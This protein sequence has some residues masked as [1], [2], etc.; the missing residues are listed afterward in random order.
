MGFSKHEPSADSIILNMMWL[1][2]LCKT[3]WKMRNTGIDCT[4]QF[5]LCQFS[6]LNKE[7]MNAVL[8]GGHGVARLCICK[9][10]LLF[11]PPPFTGPLANFTPAAFD[12]QPEASVHLHAGWAPGPD[13]GPKAGQLRVPSPF[14]GCGAARPA[15]T[16][17]C[18]SSNS[19]CGPGARGFPAEKKKNIKQTMS[20]VLSLSRTEL[21]YLLPRRIVYCLYPTTF[22]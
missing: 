20:C 18:P 10:C 8:R 15:R 1:R 19:V 5:Q 21:D 17:S 9:D 6:T 13:L 4:M 22:C 3:T 2:M 11:L 7:R 16:L 14:P 12:L